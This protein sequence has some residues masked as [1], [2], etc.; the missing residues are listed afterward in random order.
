MNQ[1]YIDDLSRLITISEIESLAVKKKK[2]KKSLQ[3]KVQFQIASKANS[4][5]EV[6]PILFKLFQKIEEEGTLPM[7]F[8]EAIITLTLKPEKDTTKK[9]NYMLISLMNIHK[10]ILL[11]HKE[12]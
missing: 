1:E 3:T 11:S 10:G 9:E 2:K 12:E 5:I 6:I 7:T 8:Y 4:T